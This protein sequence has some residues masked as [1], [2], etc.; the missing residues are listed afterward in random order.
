MLMKVS[1]VNDNDYLSVNGLGE[2]AVVKKKK[3]SSYHYYITPD[4][5]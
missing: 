1:T 2:I 5:K 4:N 3:C